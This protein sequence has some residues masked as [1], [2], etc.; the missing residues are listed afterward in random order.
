MFQ[1][2]VTEESRVNIALECDDIDASDA[3][4]FVVLSA[5]S[6]HRVLSVSA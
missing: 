6:A 3:I 5:S 4:G 2:A 1:F